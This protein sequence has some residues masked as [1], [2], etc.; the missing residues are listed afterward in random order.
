MDVYELD[1]EQ[2]LWLLSKVTTAQNILDNAERIYDYL[3]E[4]FDQRVMDSV[5]REWSFQWSTE[6]LN[7][8]YQVIYDKWLGE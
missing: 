6:V 8:D 2:Y 4:L 1:R 7:I 5:I 3:T